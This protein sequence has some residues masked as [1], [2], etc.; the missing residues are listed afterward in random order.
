MTDRVARF[1]DRL[2]A[3]HRP[4]YAPS[5]EHLEAFFDDGEVTGKSVFDAGCGCGIFSVI[6]AEK[7]A[8][9]TGAD[10]SAGAIEASEALKKERGVGNVEFMRADML[11]LPFEDSSFDIVWAWGSVHHTERPMDALDELLRVL[12][13]DGVILL[14][15][16]R[17]SRLTFLHGIATRILSRTPLAVQP[18]LAG[19]ISLPLYPFITLFKKREKMR[20]GETLAH[21]V[22]DWFFVP[23]RHH[24]DPE[25]I[26]LYMQSK[27]F[28]MEKAI[29]TASRFDSTSNFI[30]KMRRAT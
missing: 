11:D 16:Y 23:I 5:R 9:V 28:G 14:A 30:F 17:K 4:E 7:G 18:F 26:R 13:D 20:K 3:R 22:L 24:Y 12:K 25:E 8:I 10:V 15:L 6:C 21:L 19:L 1:Y 27:G 29:V 2:W